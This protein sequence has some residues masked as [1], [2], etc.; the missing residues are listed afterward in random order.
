LGKKL[1]IIFLLTVVLLSLILLSS[2]FGFLAFNVP[3][4]SVKELDLNNNLSFSNE[5][6]VDSHSGSGGASPALFCIRGVTQTAY[7]RSLVCESYGDGN[8]LP[9]DAPSVQ[10]TDNW[11]DY[12]VT[13]YSSASE[14]DFQVQPFSAFGGFIPST[15][16]TNWVS[17]NS[18]LQYFSDQQVFYS[19][20]TFLN[21]YN[22]SYTCYKFDGTTL[23]NAETTPDNRYLEVPTNMFQELNTL[24]LKITQNLSSPF[25]QATAIADFL[26]QNYHYDLDYTPAP[27]GVDPVIWFLFNSTRGVCTHFNSAFV[28]LARSIGIPA[29]LC[30]GFLIDPSSSYQQVTSMQRHAYAEVLFKDLGWITFDA[31]APANSSEVGPCVEI[32]YPAQGS[33]VSGQR[34]SVNGGIFGFGADANVSINNPSF[35]LTTWNS[36]EGVFSFSNSSFVAD[37]KYSVNVSAVD[38]SGN[39]ASAAVTFTV[40]NTSPRINIE[41]PTNGTTVENPSIPVDGN[42]GGADRDDLKPSINDSRFLLADWN[43]SSG[44]FSFV[45]VTDLAGTVSLQV[46][47]TNTGG[48]SGSSSVSFNVISTARFLTETTITYC[49]SVGIKGSNFTVQGL[50]TEFNGT[51]VNG[52]QV[53]VYLT[54]SKSEIGTICGQGETVNGGYFNISCHVDV[55]VQVGEYQIVAHNVGDVLYAD[56]W[57]DPEITIM[58]ETTLSLTFPSEVIMGRPFTVAGTLEETLSHQ[59]IPNETI[60]LGVQGGPVTIYPGGLITVNFGWNASVQ[61]DTESLVTDSEG[62]FSLNLTCGTP[63][64]FTVPLFFGGSETYLNSSASAALKILGITISPT[65]NTT[66]IRSGSVSLTGRVLAG[67]LPVDDEPLDVLAGGKEI[68][69]REPTDSLGYFNFTLPVWNLYSSFGNQSLGPMVIEY[70]DQTLPN[71]FAKQNVT[72]MA[73]TWLMGA[74]TQTLKPTDTLNITGSLMDDVGQPMENMSV[75]LECAFNKLGS[76][77]F[78]GTTGTDGHFEYTGV[79]IPSRTSGILN[80][81]VTFL[82]N[83]LYLPS[84]FHG[85]VTILQTS[86][87]YDLLLIV[88]GISVPAC[89]TVI[90]AVV[91]KKKKGSQVQVEQTA[92]PVLDVPPIVVPTPHTGNEVQLLIRFPQIS[93]QFPIVWGVNEAL[94][95]EVELESRDKPVSAE[96]FSVRVDDE[97]E[98]SFNGS[99]NTFRSS[100]VFDSKGVHTLKAFSG[101]NGLG[102]LALEVA[103]KIVDYREEI[104]DLFNSFFKSAKTKFQGVHDEMTPRELQKALAGQVSLSEQKS[105]ETAVSIFEVA[106]YSLHQVDRENYERMYTALIKLGG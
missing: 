45:N 68:V 5:V 21:S 84:T 87:P 58:A 18:P 52:L 73:R 11:I 10:Y 37:G 95:I 51:G 89:L 6:S 40:D 33:T 101:K 60:G 19:D 48:I 28:L 17:L 88:F 57:S 54:Q 32:F 7:L 94:A 3:S 106:D 35:G 42:I 76:S 49:S 81:T 86:G 50:V 85:S 29:R 30:T 20:N 43:S 100:C 79:L 25:D 67:D 90:S 2:V 14:V 64:N 46:S 92:S 78:T 96:S 24:A 44:V 34:I 26:R 38:G 98:L 71:V 41:Y 56:S 105:L 103:V 62:T 22:V 59:P 83:D 102:E 53:V 75:K 70:D 63:G 15:K 12:N 4:G 13:E 99:G 82:G 72:I 55:D 66:L 36:T 80:Y 93:D 74:A 47:F 104:V 27:S 23:S 16:E 69:W 8:W 61:I 65:T 91:W 39:Q 9:L 77:T 97:R 1:K 31:T